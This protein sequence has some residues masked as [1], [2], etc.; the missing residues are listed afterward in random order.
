MSNFTNQPDQGR[1]AFVPGLLGTL[2]SELDEGSDLDW[3]FGSLE[4]S[5]SAVRAAYLSHRLPPHV[6]ASLL[7]ELKLQGSDG[8]LWTVGA[9]SG[10]WWRKSGDQWEQSG[11]PEGIRVTGDI[12][13]WVANGIGKEIAAS[14][15]AARAAFGVE[16]PVPVAPVPIV[17]T[18]LT[19]PER[20]SV[21]EEINWLLNEWDSGQSSHSNNHQVPK[22]GDADIPSS[23]P[24]RFQPTAGLDLSIQAL[25]GQT[26]PPVPRSA[27]EIDKT[28]SDVEEHSTYRQTERDGFV[29]PQEFFLAPDVV[30]KPRDALDDEINTTTSAWADLQSS[31]STIKHEEAALEID[32]SATRPI[33]LDDV[34]SVGRQAHAASRSDRDHD[35]VDKNQDPTNESESITDSTSL[36]PTSPDQDTQDQSSALYDPLREDS[37]SDNNG[38]L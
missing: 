20:A 29:L 36:L 11:S 4:A 10:S 17:V 21:E 33:T 15:S 16:E 2:R 30:E 35:N 22:I 1:S 26:A 24:S 34:L 37:D 32:L 38:Y 25:T 19:K 12:P 7:S 9:S 6:A 8:A 27:S 14:E 5:V 31:D 18:P 13:S 3:A 28:I 23:I